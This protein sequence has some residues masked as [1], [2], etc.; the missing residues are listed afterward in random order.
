MIC[1]IC[2]G[3]FNFCCILIDVLDFR[4]FFFMVWFVEDWVIILSGMIGILEGCFS[5]GVLVV[6]VLFEG[7]VLK[8]FLERWNFEILVL[9]VLIND[10]L[11]K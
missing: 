10:G 1:V 9:N 6:L 11:Y 2:N 3:W 5:D 7:V 4:S 8:G